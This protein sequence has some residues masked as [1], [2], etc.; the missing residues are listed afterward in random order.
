MEAASGMPLGAIEM[1]AAWEEQFA[2]TNQSADTD[3]CPKV[4]DMVNR[5]KEAQSGSPAAQTDKLRETGS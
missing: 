3:S 1:D 4:A 2:F 5:L